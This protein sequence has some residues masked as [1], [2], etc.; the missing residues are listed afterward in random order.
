M[1]LKTLALAAAMTLVLASA[2]AAIE[3]SGELRLEK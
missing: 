1:K 2:Q 3:E